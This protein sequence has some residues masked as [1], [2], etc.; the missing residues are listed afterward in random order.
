MLQTI[1]GLGLFVSVAICYD[2]LF[3]YSVQG[4]ILDRVF[5]SPTAD[6]FAQESS[7]WD[8]HFCDENESSSAGLGE[9]M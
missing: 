7:L 5:Q 6:I 4:Y 9:F 8:G 3:S 1:A 2:I